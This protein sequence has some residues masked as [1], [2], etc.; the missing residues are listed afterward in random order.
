MTVERDC[1]SHPAISMLISSTNTQAPASATLRDAGR[2][3]VCSFLKKLILI[4]CL[5]LLHFYGL[6]I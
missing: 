1:H 2:M 6:N 4:F 5:N 3:S